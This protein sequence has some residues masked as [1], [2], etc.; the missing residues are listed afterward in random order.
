MSTTKRKFDAI[1]TFCVCVECAAHRLDRLQWWKTEVSTVRTGSKGLETRVATGWSGLGDKSRE[2]YTKR[3]TF[4][5]RK[6]LL[7]SRTGWVRD[8]TEEGIEPNPGEMKRGGKRN[9]DGKPDH[10]RA[11][12]PDQG[13]RSRHTS[14]K[15]LA[16]QLRE[17]NTATLAARDAA[18]EFTAEADRDE[19]KQTPKEKTALD[20][21]KEKVA[22]RRE[23]DRYE[24]EEREKIALEDT[25]EFNTYF[26]K[27]TTF[28]E[29]FFSKIAICV[30]INL[31]FYFAVLAGYYCRYYY[32]VLT[33][34]DMWIEKCADICVSYRHYYFDQIVDNLDRRH[35]TLTTLVMYLGCFV[36]GAVFHVLE[37]KMSYTL[38]R[39]TLNE[40]QK[41][42][43]KKSHF[44]GTD[45]RPDV[46]N[47]KKLER[48]NPIRMECVIT[49]SLGFRKTDYTGEC[50]FTS[51]TH[52]RMAVS[53]ELFAQM[54][55]ARLMRQTTKED[56]TRARMED[57]IASHQGDNISRY[58][59]DPVS[60]ATV[61]LAIA[62]WR[63]LQ[64]VS[65]RWLN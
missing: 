2:D 55:N 40:K 21:L 42:N 12:R 43:D 63:H 38:D 9:E 29:G 17:L 7:V 28:S 32:E 54:N 18:K 60:Q 53:L 19:P 4:G 24:S 15:A 35:A 36:I 47:M 45:L 16:E 11:K 46:L 34:E 59:L 39:N 49:K 57:F 51:W 10:G 58:D 30:V 20:I 48:Y 37:V 61:S 22:E 33:Y 27:K 31:L 25:L 56:V 5:G 23:I 65:G 64:D 50:I 8:L 62:H 13:R 41:W 3:R 44:R 52:E 14:T 6:R 26:W 1:R